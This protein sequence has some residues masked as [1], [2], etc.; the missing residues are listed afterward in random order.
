MAYAVLVDTKKCMAC[1]G[2][3]VACKDWNRLPAGATKF[4][5]SYTN[6]PTLEAHT[7]NH[8]I[9]SETDQGR[10][11]FANYACMHC[12]DAACVSVC[13]AGA[14][15]R[16]KNGTVWPDPDKCIGCGLCVQH[17]P[18]HVPHL[19][20]TTN[21]MGKCTGCAER[22][23]QGLRPACVTTCP[24][25]ALQYGERNALLQQAKERVQSL[26][27]QGFAQA[28]IYGENEMHGLG[29]IYILT[30]RPAAYGLPENPCYSASAWIWQL[31]R[32]PLGKLASVGLFSGLVVG[33][34]RW[35]G[36]RIQH[37]GDNTM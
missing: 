18:F 30:E 8:L 29:R 25:G 35:R 36:D 23:S 10:W 20:K 37:K 33:F 2:C 11:L 31:A 13:P 17:C 26:R 6:P 16:T 14:V 27:E 15:Q 19:S 9:F 34:L 24:N 1:R 12:T 7:W 5:G 4:R 28:N 3:Q 21:K 22:T 32:R